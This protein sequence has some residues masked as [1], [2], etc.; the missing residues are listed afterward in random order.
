MIL[1]ALLPSQ[2]ETAVQI[3]QFSIEIGQFSNMIS[4]LLNTQILN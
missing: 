4:S 3:Q 2:S 1:E